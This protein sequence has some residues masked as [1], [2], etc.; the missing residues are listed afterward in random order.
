MFKVMKHNRSTSSRPTVLVADDSDYTR[1][2]Y[3]ELLRYEGFEVDTAVDG[4]DAMRKAIVQ[5]PDALVLDLTVPGLTGSEVAA[6]LK[7]DARTKRVQIV[8]VSGHEIPET[9]Y[10]AEADVDA[11][12]V[13]PCRPEAL[14]EAIARQLTTTTN[15]ALPPRPASTPRARPPASAASS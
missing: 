12:L 6:G 5:P 4:A 1:E 10:C 3:A 15:R 14:I 2:M 7:S 9:K 11:Y 13:K 8:A